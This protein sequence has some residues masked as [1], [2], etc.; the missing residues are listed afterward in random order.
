MMMMMM[1][2]FPYTQ[3]VRVLRKPPDVRVNSCGVMRRHMV[4]VLCYDVQV[5]TTRDLLEHWSTTYDRI[6][7]S[8]SCRSEERYYYYYSH[9]ALNRSVKHCHFR[10]KGRSVNFRDRSEQTGRHA[11]MDGW[12]D[13]K[14][15]V[16]QTFWLWLSLERTLQSRSTHLVR[17]LSQ[18]FSQ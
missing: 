10:H 6:P 13:R 16:I 17:Q 18:Y 2:I 7:F 1:M 15:Y 3:K 14:K 9:T 11:C 8:T 5:R 4:T 12:M